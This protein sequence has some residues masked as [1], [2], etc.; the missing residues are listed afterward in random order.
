MSSFKVV[1]LKHG[2]PSTAAERQVV[3]AAGG[4]F[5]DLDV[6]PDDE[7]A[8][9]CREADAIL[10]RWVRITPELIRSFVR[11]KIVIRFGVGFD[12]IDVNAATEAGIMVGHV[13]DYCLDEVST[14][15]IGLLLA[16]VRNLTRSQRRLAA[17]GWD[18][19]PSDKIWRVAGKTLGLVGFGNIGRAVARKLQGWGVRMLASDPYVDPFRAADLGVRLVDLAALCRESDYVSLHVPLLPETRHLISRTEFELM[20]PG[21]MIVNTARGPIIDEAALVEAL[22]SGR[23]AHA[24][25]DVFEHEPLPAD[26]PLRRH[27]RVTL[28]DHVAWYSEESEHDLKVSAAQEAVRVAIGGLPRSLAN[29]EVLHRLGRW[30]EWTPNDSARWRLKRL[31]HLAS[32]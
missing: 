8:R 6:V 29:P 30:N 15:A 7:G 9:Y 12:N 1:F 23:V 11:C 4:E 14:H 3:E 26:S 18:D 16:G 17:G 24:G 32:A 27:L 2:Y 31:E 19:L 22:D 10:V 5:V 21:V 13:P 25:L 20:K 28:S